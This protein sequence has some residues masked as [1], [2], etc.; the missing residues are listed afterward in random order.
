MQKKIVLFY[1]DKFIPGSEIRGGTESIEVPK[2][3]GI[4]GKL[5]H[6]E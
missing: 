2:I 4:D 1:F 3:T 6:F 5:F